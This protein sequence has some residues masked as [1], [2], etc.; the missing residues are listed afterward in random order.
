MSAEQQQ[1]HA[2]Y[3]PLTAVGALLKSSREYAIIF[4]RQSCVT[5]WRDKKIADWRDIVAS[6]A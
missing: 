6:L 3:P 1:L 5:K 2:E 4:L